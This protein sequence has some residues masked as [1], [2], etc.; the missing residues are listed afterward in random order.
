MSGNWELNYQVTDHLGGVVIALDD[1]G[2]IESMH[3]YT[4]F[5][6]ALPLTRK[7]NPE[8]FIGKETNFE[9]GFANHRVR[10]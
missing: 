4:P 7:Q 2:E 6:K 1:C 5:G 10:K 9:T 8:K 3:E